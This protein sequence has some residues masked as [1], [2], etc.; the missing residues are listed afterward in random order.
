MKK[1]L[2]SALAVSAS[3]AVSATAPAF[4]PSRQAA[5]VDI[6]QNNPDYSNPACASA[7]N[8]LFFIAGQFDD[9]FTFTQK[10]SATESIDYVLDAED[11]TSAY[12]LA[13]DIN[14]MPNVAFMIG[15]MSKITAMAADMENLYIA[16][17]YSGKIT[18]KSASESGPSQEVEGLKLNDKPVPN[19]SASFIAVYDLKG[20]F[21]S[22]KTFVPEIL[23]D[24]VPKMEELSEWGEPL[25]SPSGAD[26]FFHIDDLQVYDG[27]LYF[28]AEYTGETK[29]GNLTLDGTY[30]DLYGMFM[31]DVANSAVISLD[32]ETLEA[33]A[34]EMSAEAVGPVFSDEQPLAGAITFNIGKAGLFGAFIPAGSGEITVKNGALS[35]T[36][37]LSSYDKIDYYILTGKD[38]LSK[39]AKN[40]GSAN[41]HNIISNLIVE[42]NKVYMIGSADVEIPSATAG[43][44]VAVTGSNDIFV[45]TFSA[46]DLSFIDVKGNANNEGETVI[47]N[48]DGTSE[49]KPNYELPIGAVTTNDYLFICTK[50]NTF[51]GEYVS[52]AS[53]LFTGEGYEKPVDSFNNNPYPG[54]TGIA[55]NNG[56][57][58]S[59][60]Y[61]YACIALPISTGTSFTFQYGSFNQ[62]IID[63]AINEIAA[64][65]VDANAPVEYFNL[66]G[67]RIVEPTPGSIVIRRQGSNVEKIVVK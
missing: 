49:A 53:T 38:K 67:I 28:S 66:Q 23:P 21:K 40:S 10:V 57:G 26:L 9:S 25:Y 60:D 36:L 24:L 27:K 13:Y 8:K 17:V 6:T 20:N 55:R 1:L 29:I 45:A 16:G 22:A 50:T 11:Y 3:I 59:A 47:P 56:V 12:V 63:S 64:D 2:L 65:H 62:D 61:N 14:A 48:S 18:F 19:Q 46:S 34:V 30:Q 52:S 51:K 58:T 54:A 43:E 44:G 7:N 35:E 41:S 33:A 42:R 5:T 39:L 32:T 37:S 4:N 31:F 15:G